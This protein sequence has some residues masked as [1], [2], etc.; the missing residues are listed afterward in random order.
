M[1]FCH[2]LW[3]RPPCR[4]QGGLNG[5]PLSPS[6][7][8]AK[9]TTGPGEM[10]GAFT[11]FGAV[12]RCFFCDVCVLFMFYILCFC[13]ADLWMSCDFVF[14][15]L[16]LFGKVFLCFVFFACFL[17]CFFDFVFLRTCFLC[18]IVF[19]HFFYVCFVFFLFFFASLIAR[20]ARRIYGVWGHA[21]RG[22][23]AQ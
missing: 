7:L 4:P 23:N 1:T 19:F 17:N 11:V 14:F 6:D 5:P 13:I 9:R 3:P 10:P 8:A 12:L 22:Y 16:I 20:N 18:V 21:G 15:S 2:F